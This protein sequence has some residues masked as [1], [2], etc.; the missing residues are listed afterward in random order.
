MGLSGLWLQLVLRGFLALKL[1]RFL[2]RLGIVGSIA[3]PFSIVCYWV[4]YGFIRGFL[5]NL[6]FVRIGLGDDDLF[7]RSLVALG[8]ACL[9]QKLSDYQGKQGFVFF[10]VCVLEPKFGG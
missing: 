10:L 8:A 9:P 3:L 5:T 7:K 1:K 6:A 2:I 4:G